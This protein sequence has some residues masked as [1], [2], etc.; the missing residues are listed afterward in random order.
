MDRIN[1][2]VHLSTPSF[3]TINELPTKLRYE[4][5]PQQFLLENCAV[6]LFCPPY[7]VSIEDALMI[8]EFMTD[9][10]SCRTRG[11]LLVLAIQTYMY[12]VLQSLRLVYPL[13]MPSSSFFVPF[14]ELA[15]MQ[16]VTF[17][18]DLSISSIAGF[19]L[20]L[21]KFPSLLVY[22]YIYLRPI[23]EVRIYR[24]IRR[25]LPK[26]YLADELSIR[27]ALE[28]DLIDWMAPTLGRRSEEENLR[29]NLTLWEDVK[30]ELAMI[31]NWTLSW[32]GLK[33]DQKINRTVNASP[34]EERIESLRQIVEDLQNELG[35]ERPRTGQER[36]PLRTRPQITDGQDR[37]GYLEGVQASS[38]VPNLSQ[39]TSAESIFDRER[40]LHNEDNRVSQSPDAM[41]TDY[42]SEMDPMANA[43]NVASDNR[44]VGD[45]STP[46]ARHDQEGPDNRRVSRSDTLFSRPSSPETSPP[47]SPR[48]RASLIHQNSDII[49]MQLE[50]LGNRG[51]GQ[52]QANLRPGNGNEV[53][54]LDETSTDRRSITEFLDSLLANENQNLEAIMNTDAIDS[55]G[56]SNLTA[57]VSPAAGY[58]QL[59]LALPPPD[60][61]HGSNV[62]TVV[63]AP[64]APGVANIL[65]DNV[66]EPGDEDIPDGLPD[67]DIGLE[68]Q[69]ILEPPPTA[70][71]NPEPEHDE[72]HQDQQPLDNGRPPA[73]RVTILSLH[74]VDSLAS[75]LAS[76]IT[77]VVFLPLE[78]LY[79]RSLASAH[80]S[81]RGS[82][83]LLSD[84]RPLGAW[85]GGGSIMDSV[86]YVG[87]M[88]LMLGMQGAVNATVW[89]ILSGSAI[90]IGKRFCG[91]GSL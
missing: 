67:T 40:I 32:T 9:R 18:T 13:C 28:N 76:M 71:N 26:P 72:Q 53:A 43:H 19:G 65:P 17:P 60:Q 57:G 80:L 82:S 55:D 8:D 88:S 87:K 69:P 36:Q 51:N 90:R 73:H 37:V 49:T 22:L 10:P 16:F 38:V 7:L 44:Q 11:A 31:W 46:D 81:S 3:G 45:S 62:D 64:A 63:D 6:Y 56:L 4:A 20:G 29:G 68:N 89:G 34:R 85:T 30:Y 84:V 61:D 91:W 52:G 25:H 54:S 41:S 58:D 86:A 35:V 66:E 1:L 39:Q 47:T 78:S 75:H 83:A 5:L 74:P 77:T 21:F 24:L 12:S 48:V 2:L 79:L 23:M 14:G 33:R 59:A 15:P 50:L 70:L 42:L 27:V